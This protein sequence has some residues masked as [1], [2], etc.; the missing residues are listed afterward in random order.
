MTTKLEKMARE[1]AESRYYDVK[2]VGK[3]I[4]EMDIKCGIEDFIDGYKACREE[5]WK[6]LCD[7]KTRATNT[8]PVLEA[9][10][11]FGDEEESIPRVEP[12][13]AKKYRIAIANKQAEVIESQGMSWLHMIQGKVKH[14]YGD[15]EHQKWESAGGYLL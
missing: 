7:P 10:R 8:L 2:S 14:A 6:Y 4:I 13:V 5:I 12:I 15:W 1:R 3:D 11:T 9:V